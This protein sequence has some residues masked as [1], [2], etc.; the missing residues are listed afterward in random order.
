M[1]TGARLIIS[2]AG[3]NG[4]PISQVVVSSDSVGPLLDAMFFLRRSRLEIPLMKLAMA[5]TATDYPFSCV[6]FS[7][8]QLDRGLVE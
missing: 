2:L 7:V 4:W 1:Q 5:T 3:F 6:D 8:S